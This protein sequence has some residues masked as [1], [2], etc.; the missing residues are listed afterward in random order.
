MRFDFQSHIVHD[1]F[2]EI[3]DIFNT[4]LKIVYPGYDSIYLWITTKYGIT[5]VVIYGPIYEHIEVLPDN[6]CYSYSRFK[7]SDKKCATIIHKYLDNA[8]QVM[9]T[10]IDEICGKVKDFISY[11]RNEN[12]N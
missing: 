9:E 11:V 3:D 1:D 7:A 8:T 4:C 2:I 5:E 10:E 12:G 6:V